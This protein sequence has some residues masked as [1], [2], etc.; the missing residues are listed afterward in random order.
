MEMF[1]CIKNLRMDNTHRVEFTQGKMYVF[2]R[3]GRDWLGINN[4]QEA[5]WM[6][7]EDMKEF[8]VGPQ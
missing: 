2:K 3:S 8:F 1:Y 7:P 5:H 4:S 6:S